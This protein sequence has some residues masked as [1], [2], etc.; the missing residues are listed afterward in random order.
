MHNFI[1][2][3]RKAYDADYIE[4]ELL[5]DIQEDNAQELARELREWQA[6]QA[7]R[8]RRGLPLDE[9]PEHAALEPAEAVIGS[10]AWLRGEIM[11]QM[12]DDYC[13]KRFLSDDEREMKQRE[14]IMRR[15]REINRRGVGAP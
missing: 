11:R 6:V 13:R 4:T 5:V 15:A 10:G 2:H 8:R 12:W 14:A 9:I 7:E 1:L 3:H